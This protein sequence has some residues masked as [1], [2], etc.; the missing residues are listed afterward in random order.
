MRVRTH[1]T[2]LVF[3]HLAGYA[4]HV[5]HFGALEAQN[6]VELF[7]MLGWARCNFH[8][9]HVGTRYAKLVFLHPV[10]SAGHVVH[11]GE[12]G[13]EMTMHYF[14]AWVALV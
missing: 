13:H 1:Y 12:S 4:G 3:L 11:S 7:F 5:L 10:G 14:H 6:I 9:K 8:K 2:K